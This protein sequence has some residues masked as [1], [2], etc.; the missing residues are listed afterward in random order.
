LKKASKA[1][2]VMGSAENESKSVDSFKINGLID[3]K[4]N[5]Y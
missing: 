1:F 4:N 3:E 5:F 2:D